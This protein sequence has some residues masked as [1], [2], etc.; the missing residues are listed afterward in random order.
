MPYID[1]RAQLDADGRPE[2]VSITLPGGEEQDVAVGDHRLVLFQEVAATNALVAP[3]EIYCE[4]DCDQ[5]GT[6]AGQV[7]VLVPS[8][9]SPDQWTAVIVESGRLTNQPLGRLSSLSQ[10][11]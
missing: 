9:P 8:S 4:R 7:R 5:S 2:S 11:R 3:A 1:C 10:V 6:A